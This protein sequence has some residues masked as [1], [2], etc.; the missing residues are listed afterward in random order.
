TLD[1]SLQRF[2]EN[3]VARGLDRL[4]TSVPRLRR[5]SPSARLQAALVAL[6]PATAEIRALVG[7]RDYRT[8]QFNR[9]LMA[10]RQP[11][12]AFKPFV[13]AASLSPQNGQ[14]RFT[15][16]SIVD[17]SPLTIQVSGKPWTPR[18]YE[19]RYQ[20]RVTLR[21]ALE[22]S[23]N[24]A[25]VRIAQAVGLPEVVATAHAFGFGDN[26]APVPAVALGAFEVTPVD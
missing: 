15:A 6:D 21:R 16:A 11:G 17:D 8:S 4:E 26:L 5:A 25:T 19:E 14:T 9:A 24:S 18:N 23:L 7:G 13:Y 20:G 22:Q 12:S 3:A 10:R 2:A 1:P